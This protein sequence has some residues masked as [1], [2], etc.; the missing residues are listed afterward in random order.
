MRRPFNG[1]TESLANKISS[2]DF[3]VLG[4]CSAPSVTAGAG[5]PDGGVRAMLRA[6]MQEPTASAAANATVPA[7][8]LV[9]LSLFV[10]RSQ[11]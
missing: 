7:T 2:P 6:E 10:L 1:S 5:E 3:L 9:G 11:L 4:T 8:K